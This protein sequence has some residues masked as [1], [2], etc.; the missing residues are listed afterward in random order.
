[1]F[2]DF[3]N[4]NIVWFIAWAV[5]FN[6]LVF[7]YIRGGI[8]GANQVSVLEMPALQRSGKSVIIDVNK[9]EQYALSHIPQALNIPLEDIGDD[10]SALLK[11]KD[12]TV[13]LACQSGGRSQTAAK[14]LVALGFSKVNILRGGL[15]AWTKENLPVESSKENNSK[16]KK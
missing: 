7:S 15:M 6:L 5:L 1:M 8:S 13:I 9:P 3:I 16:T 2:V 12:K 14:Q 11:H 10:N 4:Q